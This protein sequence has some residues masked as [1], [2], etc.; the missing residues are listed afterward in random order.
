MKKL[1]DLLSEAPT[2][3]F[4]DTTKQTIVSADVS[5]Y[6]LGGML[7]QDHNGQLKPVAYCSRTLTPAEKGYAQMF[8]LVRSS[9]G[10]W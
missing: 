4:Y 2:L 9:S 6:G 7:L 8:G 3:A 1:K 10:T 5:S